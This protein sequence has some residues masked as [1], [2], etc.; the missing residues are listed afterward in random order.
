ML[1][2]TKLVVFLAST[3]GLRPVLR[4]LS[5]D[6]A[7]TIDRLEAESFSPSDFGDFLLL[8]ANMYAHSNQPQL[9]KA[10]YDSLRTYAEKNLVRGLTR[11]Y[12][13][14]LGQAYAGLGLKEQAIREA[15]KGVES[16][17]VSKD[18]FTGPLYVIK[19]AM[20]Y[21]LVGEHDLAIDRLAYLLS[22]PS[23]LSANLLRLD[24]F[25]EPIRDHP[26]FKQLLQK[27]S[28]KGS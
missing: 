16:L 5:K 17:P 21:L 4:I 12:T 3:D 2:K 15:K 27:Y 9:K 20:I 10:Y 11:T 14:Y 7:S 13:Y 19:L 25:W 28:A 23:P 6:Y 1:G 22:I 24:P 18:T 8:K 26:K